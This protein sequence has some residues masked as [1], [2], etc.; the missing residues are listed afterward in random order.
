RDCPKLTV[1]HLIPRQQARRKKQDA[2]PTVDI[3]APCHKQVHT[4]FTNQQLAVEFNSVEQLHAHEG[5]QK[6]LGWVRKQDPTRKVR[7]R[8]AN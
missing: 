7:T 5:M 2:G 6:F 1:H 3:C 8:R 4:L